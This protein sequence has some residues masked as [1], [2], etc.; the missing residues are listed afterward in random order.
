MKEIIEY[1]IA[2]KKTI[3]TMESATGGY[4][5]SCLTNIEGSS[6]V[7]KYGTITYSNEFKIKMG[8]S[9]DI[10]DT[11]TVYSMETA[12]EMSKKIT[13]FTNSDYGVGV[14]GKINTPDPFNNFG[15]DSLI[16]LSIYDKKNNC[17]FNSQI[18]AI[19]EKRIDN[20]ELVVLEFCKL[21]Q[22]N[23]LK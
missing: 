14:T 9:K 13:D 20:K 5:A 2:N 21:F 19:R 8:V 6:L 23:I 4:L 18:K 3:S 11:Y 1:L 16:F 17:Y 12:N 10:I 15:D 22:E 7:F